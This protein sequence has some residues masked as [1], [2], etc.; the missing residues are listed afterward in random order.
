MP[1]AGKSTLMNK[2]TDAKVINGSKELRRIC[3]GSFSELSEEE[4]SQVRIRYTEYI[5]SL[6]DEWIVSD[7]HYSFMENVVFTEADGELYD[8]FIYLYCAPEVLKERYAASEKNAAFVGESVEDIK[9]WQ[10][11]EIRSLREECHK[12]NK[13]FYVIS[14]NE[15]SNCMFYEFLDMVKNG[16]STYK[17]ANEI[18]QKI[19]LSYPD[20]KTIHIVDGDKTIIIEDSYRFCCNGKTKVFDGDFYTGYQS[21][22]FERELQT[23]TVDENK[24]TDIR[25]NGDVYDKVGISDY[26][27][28]S[29][30]IERLWSAIE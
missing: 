14:D 5:N 24:I 28:L 6:E 3:G 11:F 8:V 21:F 9:Q 25:M 30:G 20:D 4:K 23:A 26:V 10:N 19:M 15:T 7:G 12:R 27:I 2:I 1:C 17:I 22:L 16:F 13:D 29:S 18:A